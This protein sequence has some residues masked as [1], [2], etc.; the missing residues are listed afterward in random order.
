MTSY[1]ESDAASRQDESRGALGCLIP[2]IAATVLLAIAT[3]LISWLLLGDEEDVGSDEAEVT[4]TET[5]ESTADE[6]PADDVEPRE[7]LNAPESSGVS[8]Q[9]IL[10]V[11]Q[12]GGWVE[13]GQ[14]EVIDLKSQQQITRKFRRHDEH[15]AVTIHSHKDDD[16]AQAVM[17]KTDLPARAIQFEHKVVVVEPLTAGAKPKVEQLADRLRRFRDLLGEQDTGE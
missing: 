1:Q 11:V 3:T 4:I 16:G 13:F 14:P 2:L 8:S 12:S 9:A 15:I 7:A 17:E 10:E 6:Q 5:D